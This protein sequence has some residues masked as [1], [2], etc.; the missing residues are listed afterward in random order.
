MSAKA[1]IVVGAG[2]GLGSALCRRFAQGGLAVAAA[3]R[4]GDKAQPL[5]EE[6]GGRAYSCDAGKQDDVE[7]LFTRVERELGTPE[8]VVFNPGGFQR[9]GIL[10]MNAEQVTAHW[11]DGCLGGFHVGQAAAAAMNSQGRGTIIF[12]GATASL[13]GGAGFANL[14]MPKFGLRALAQ[15]MARELW[16]QGIHVAH[17][18]IDG[19]IR[20]ESRGPQYSE[21]ERGRDALLHPEAIAEAYW[22][23]HQQP[24]NAWTHELDL[25]PWVETF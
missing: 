6:I 1:A 23:L 10:E 13:R 22:D 12:T 2:P 8:L 9:A 17:T 4:Q 21:A 11:R 7:T 20:N 19:Q 24:R 3:R 14:A 18:I 25:R 15:A 5:A 16:P